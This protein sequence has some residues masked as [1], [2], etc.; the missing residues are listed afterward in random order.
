MIRNGGQMR[1]KM[2]VLSIIMLCFCIFGFIFMNISLYEPHGFGVF[3]VNIYEDITEDYGHSISGMFDLLTKIMAIWA[4]NFFIITIVCLFIY[5]NSEVPVEKPEECI[6]EK[7]RKEK[8][9]KERQMKFLHFLKKAKEH[10]EDA[11]E[12]ID[13]VAEDAVEAVKT[14]TTAAV[15]AEKKVNDFLSKLR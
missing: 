3:L 12:V 15:N 9:K 13:E 6:H 1:K 14:T 5:A 10:P 11:K 8:L 7:E 2:K 4:T